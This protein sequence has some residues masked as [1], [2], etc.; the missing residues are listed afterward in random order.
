[1][2]DLKDNQAALKQDAK[3][4]SSHGHARHASPNPRVQGDSH[5]PFGRK[6]IRW[7]I[8]KKYGTPNH[9]QRDSRPAKHKFGDPA[10]IARLNE[11]PEAHYY[12]LVLARDAKLR[13]KILL[14]LA[15]NGHLTRSLAHEAEAI[16][17]LQEETPQLLVLAIDQHLLDF[18]D[19]FCDWRQQAETTLAVLGVLPASE[20]DLARRIPSRLV[21]DILT[22]DQLLDGPLLS[23]RLEH[24][25]TSPHSPSKHDLPDQG[26]L[27]V[28]P[29]RL[30]PEKYE[31]TIHG[32]PIQLTLTQFRLLLVLARRPGWVCSSE[33]ISHQLKQFS[34]GADSGSVKTH[35][36]LLRKRLGQA[37][38]LIETV[39]GMGYRISSVNS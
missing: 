10:R 34:I 8:N 13:Q 24:L 31:V 27:Q 14:A 30:T 12:S 4:G 7:D 39:R 37:G 18:S 16:E 17:L 32:Q 33:Q 28:G 29:I 1:M 2:L 15:A 11:A 5:L 26:V 22:E 23:R 35:I 19:F 20:T 9:S 38:R 25:M 36:Y 6:P 3:S 21:D